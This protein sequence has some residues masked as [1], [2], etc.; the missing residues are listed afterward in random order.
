MYDRPGA[1]Q[2]AGAARGR[3]VLAKTDAGVTQW[4]AIMHFDTYLVYDKKPIYK[5]SWTATSTAAPGIANPPSLTKYDVVG[6][7][8]VTSL[9]KDQITVLKKPEYKGQQDIFLP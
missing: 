6:A 7:K 2:L 3:A 4:T 5:V 8:A 1:E 9:E